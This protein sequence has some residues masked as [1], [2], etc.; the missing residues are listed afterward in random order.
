MSTAFVP[1][2]RGVLFDGWSSQES[3]TLLAP[4]GQANVIASAEALSSAM[5]AQEFAESLL[6]GLRAFDGYQTLDFGP[7]LVFG[8]RPGYTRTFSW[9][10]QE[11]G[12][13]TQIQLYYAEA[14]RGY[15]ATATT[16]SSEFDRYEDQL[17]ECLDH[18]V[19]DRDLGR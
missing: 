4:D 15:T 14:A 8:G 13:V 6:K 12:R 18:L 9:Q 3:I 19:L 7:R 17:R 11:G 2:L 1:A 5:A 10:P 16:P